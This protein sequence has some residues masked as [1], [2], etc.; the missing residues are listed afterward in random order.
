MTTLHDTYWQA[1][2]AIE[3]NC[4]VT[5]WRAGDVDLWPLARQD[6]FL[7]LFRAAGGD[8]A[9]P[10]PRFAVRAASS[11]ATPLANLWKSRGDLAHWVPW[12]RR[13]GAVLL[14]DGVSLDRIDG[15]WQDRYGEPVIAGLARRDCPTFVLQPGNLARLPW[16]RPTF[17]ANTVAAWGA[18]AAALAHGPIAALPDHEA[19]VAHLERAGIAAP[20][21]TAARLSRRAKVV[22]A[23]ASMFERILRRVRPRM[24]FVVTHYAGLGPAFALACRR[25]GVL[26][27]DLQHC[28][29][30][31][32]HRGYRW[33]VLPPGGYTTLPGLFWTWS[34]AEAASIER[35]A[36]TLDLPWHRAIHGGH[37]QI[38]GFAGIAAEAIW[39][40]RFDTVAGEP[41]AREIL[42]ALQPIGGRRAVWDGLA[43]AIASAPRQWRWWI[44]RHPASTPAQDRDFAAL[45]S[46]GSANVVIEAA[47]ELPLPVLMRRMDA[48]VSLASGA[49]GEAAAFGVLAFFL[50]EEARGPFGDLIA[51]GAASVTGADK[52]VDAIGALGRAPARS[53]VAPI[54]P[55]DDTLDA[56]ERIAGDYAGLVSARH[57]QRQV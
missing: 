54:P 25:C 28:P 57:R 45:L 56:I 37:S 20:S 23:Q 24:A 39:K 32:A 55:I 43:T 42:V 50:G 29:Q 2:D 14:G 49:A 7:D 9:P 10:P 51:G 34:T 5:D 18:L 40:A 33:P 44:R 11:L 6:L 15:A 48:L 35:W 21:M 1:V 27:V 26:C 19:A 31:S 22:A 3:R 30:G 47:A 46:S 16:A 52:L 13:A 8:T 53:P 36:E 41:A 4:R 38:A 12:P 17:A